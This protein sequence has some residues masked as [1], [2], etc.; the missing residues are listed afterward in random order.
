M[1]AY[2]IRD[3][4]ISKARDLAYL[5]YYESSGRFYIELREDVTEWEMPLLLS[6]FS[7]RGVYSVGHKWSAE[8]VA[9]R[10]V[11]PERQNL[12]M[13][14]KEHH[15]EE[16]DPHALLVIADGRCA[17]DDC[18][19][20]RL[21]EGAFPETLRKRLQKKLEDLTLLGGSRILVTFRD[22]MIRHIDAA[23]LQTEADTDGSGRLHAYRDGIRALAVR[24]GGQILALTGEK[25]VAAERVRLL[26]K[27]ISLT[28]P[29]MHEYIRQNLVSTSQAAE[30]LG[31]TR[32][33]VADLVRRGRLTPFMKEGNTWL[34]LKSEL[35]S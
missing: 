34:F 1:K 9:L 27:E 6:S 13:I 20:E 22:G 35:I 19:I 26:G 16:Y 24:D 29:E 14:L 8:W 25:E 23:D 32:Q 18:Y 7:R 17:Q 28:R 31:C 3:A 30:L 5:L 11:P 21:R 33:N 2:A 12:G 10:I 15:L 4:S